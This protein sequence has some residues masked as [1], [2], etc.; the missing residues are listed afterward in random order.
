MDFVP[1]TPKQLTTLAQH[2]T[3]LRPYFAGVFASDQL[4]A[5]PIKG[6]PQGYIINVDRH[7]AQGSH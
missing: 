4:P 3:R 1:T 2:D 6:R 7:D 5:S